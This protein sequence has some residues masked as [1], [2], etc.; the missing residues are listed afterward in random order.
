MES[1]CVWKACLP[2]LVICAAVRP[3]STGYE[4]T[5]LGL[6]ELGLTEFVPIELA[7]GSTGFE[8]KVYSGAAP[9]VE[10]SGLRVGPSL[11]WPKTECCHFVTL[12]SGCAAIEWLFPVLRSARS[13]NR[14]KP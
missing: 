6:T 9:A 14:K 3:G 11:S 2:D 4:L 13:S 8:L 1:C 7:R 5:E 12:E 10:P